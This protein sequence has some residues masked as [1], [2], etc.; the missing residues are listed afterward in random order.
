MTDKS[1]TFTV[2]PTT[3]IP[4]VGTGKT[5]MQTTTIQK[6]TLMKMRTMKDIGISGR[7]IIGVTKMMMKIRMV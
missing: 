6:R 3:I 1:T 4:G 2:R 5:L 7:M